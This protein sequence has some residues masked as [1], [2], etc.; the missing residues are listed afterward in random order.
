MPKLLSRPQYDKWLKK[1]PKDYCTFCH[2]D[3]FQIIL[4]EGYE[5]VWIANIAPYWYYHTMLIPKRHFTEFGDMTNSEAIEF[6]QILSLAMKRY[7]SQKLYRPDKTLIEKYVYF[8]RKRDNLVD[9][10][11]GTTRPDHFHIHISPDQDHL[12]D[13]V[14]DKDACKV[15]ID[16]LKTNGRN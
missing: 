6:K 3:E 4:H 7:R 2:Y 12:W 16:T 14:V 10:I 8:W 13:R 5:W 15:N 1:L 11:S 9:K